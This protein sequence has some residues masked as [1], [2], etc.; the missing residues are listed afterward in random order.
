MTKQQ[1]YADLPQEL[2]Q[3]DELL[4]RY[5]RW[6]KDRV[7]PQRCASAEGHYKAPP[8]DDDREPREVIMPAA[9]VVLVNRAL[10]AVPELERKVLMWLYVPSKEPIQAKMRKNATPPRLM[11]ERHLAGVRM[12]WNNWIKYKHCSQKQPVDAY[13][14][15]LYAVST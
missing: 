8:S 7:R 9:D 11:Q 12:F 3:A 6:A 13:S 1:L 10:Q 15:I 4:R 5:G 14:N 2:L